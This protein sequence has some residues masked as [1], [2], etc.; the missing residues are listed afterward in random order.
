MCFALTELIAAVVNREGDE[1]HH[2]R[3]AYN[4]M[5]GQRQMIDAVLAGYRLQFFV[6]VVCAGSQVVVCSS[7]DRP[8][9]T[10]V[11]ADVSRL[12]EVIRTAVHREN[13][14]IEVAT[15]RLVVI[16]IMRVGACLCHDRVFVHTVHFQL[17]CISVGA[18]EDSL[19][20]IVVS[21]ILG[22]GNAI[23]GIAV[24]RL[25]K[26]AGL[27]ISLAIECDACTRTDSEVL[28]Y[29]LFHLTFYCQIQTED[30]LIAVGLRLYVRILALRV[31]V[32]AMPVEGFSAT[33][34]SRGIHGI[35]VISG[36]DQANDTIAT[37][38]VLQYGI[39]GERRR[40][41]LACHV[42]SEGLAFVALEDLRLQVHVCYV[43]TKRND[44]ITA[45]GSNE[46]V[47]INASLGELLTAEDD[48]VATANSGIFAT[49]YDCGN[50]A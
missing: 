14:T 24:I 38:T 17:P 28:L 12:V 11:L 13:Q 27:R 3:R 23:D 22:N 44:R 45:I 20:D 43:E 49:S 30:Y 40:V 1:V 10:A 4:R 32:R 47:V 16:L 7:V 15:T 33:D 6:V 18:V 46:R 41:G 42:P 35:H 48:I 25:V 5:N 37:Q 9:I 8:C 29:N 2:F 31:V 21:R 19:R 34:G 50:N 39:F 36:Q 26:C